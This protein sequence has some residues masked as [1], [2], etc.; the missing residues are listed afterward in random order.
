[1][2]MTATVVLRND[3]SAGT[4][5]TL[6]RQYADRAYALVARAGGTRTFWYVFRIADVRSTI[7]QADSTHTLQAVLDLDRAAPASTWQVSAG[8]PPVGGGVLVLLDGDRVVGVQ[9]AAPAVATAPLE[10][11]DEYEGDRAWQGRDQVGF[12]SGKRPEQK[13]PFEIVRVFYGTDRA[14]AADVQKD[15]YYGGG[16]GELTF[17][18]GEVSIPSRRPKGTIPR[19][20]WWRLEFRENPARHVA[21]ARVTSQGRDQF[22]QGI[23]SI[24]E[25]STHKHGLLFVHGYNVSFADALRRTAQLAYDLRSPDQLESP[26]VPLLYSWPSQ[27]QLLKYLTDETNIAWTRPHF[28][29]FL[30]LVLA[31]TGT[32]VLHVIAHSMGAR[33][34][35]E[36]LSVFNAATLPA[37]S[38][39]ID[40]VVF[41]APDFDADTFRDLAAAVAQRA[42]RCTLYASSADLALSASREL[43]SDLARAGESGDRLVVVNGI[44]TIDASDVDTSLMGHG[45]FGE[46]TVLGDVFYLLKDGKGPDNRFGLLRQ[47]REDLFYWQF[48]P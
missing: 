32:E 34:L 21:V 2:L 40:Q 38:A 6:L 36:C 13:T 29:E 7:E 18:I 30:R 3:L 24:Q 37:G 39:V 41:A 23:R 48:A 22:L 28:E 11:E 9:A 46:R 16:R 12:R 14:A 1:M 27:G 44:D 4:A 20:T 26:G 42:K 8:E 15:P 33:A 10:D 5:A 25:Q 43:R 35:V 47:P 19:P 17:G 45:Y 31:E